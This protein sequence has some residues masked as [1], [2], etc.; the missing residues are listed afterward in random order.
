MSSI[1][2]ASAPRL[3]WVAGMSGV[4]AGTLEAIGSDAIQVAGVTYRLLTPDLLVGLSVGQHVTVVWDERGG[5]R[6][7]TKVIL[8]AASMTALGPGVLS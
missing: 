6:Q 4:T 8:D 7:A 3:G 1:A 5:Q 2:P